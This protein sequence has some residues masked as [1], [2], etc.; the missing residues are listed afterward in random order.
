MK[1]HLLFL[2][3]LVIA[4]SGTALGQ[5]LAD[6]TGHSLGGD[7]WTGAMA[8]QKLF[9]PHANTC[10]PTTEAFVSVGNSTLGFCIDKD[11]HPLGVQS[12]ETARDACM[13]QRKRLPELGEM[14]FAC[15]Q[16]TALGVN[17]TSNV[18][19]SSNF[20]IVV[21][22]GIT[23]NLGGTVA[24]VVATFNLS[25]TPACNAASADNVGNNL[26]VAAGALEF[27]C[28]H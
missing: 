26:L 23:S 20:G 24:W 18:E 13:A 22:D 19:W 4:F 28:V 3:I 6:P 12:W 2:A 14:K 8:S 25:V 1:Q 11:P 27:R 16:L 15:T 17:P 21:W 10:N 9:T 5:T 7:M